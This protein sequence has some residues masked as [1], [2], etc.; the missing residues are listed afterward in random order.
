MSSTTINSK[1]QASALLH[2]GDVETASD[3]FGIPVGDWIDLST[4]ISPFAYPNTQISPAALTCM[5]Y[6]TKSFERASSK[7]YALANNAEVPALAACNGSQQVISMLPQ[8]LAQLPVLLPNIGYAEHTEAWRQA[9]AEINVYNALDA[10][11]AIDEIELQ[12]SN[13]NACHVVV[14]NPNNPSGITFSA[15][16]LLGWA[17]RLQGN[18]KLIIDEAFIDVAP[19]Q[20]VLNGYYHA[21]MVVL[22]SFGKF[23]GLPGLRLGFVFAT[24]D[25]GKRIKS[26][27]GLWDI[28]GPAQE[29]A[30]GAFDDVVWQRKTREA[31]HDAAAFNEALWQPLLQHIASQ[32]HPYAAQQCTLFSSYY[33]PLSLAQTWY[34]YFASHGVLL[35]LI[36]AH[37]SQAFIRVGLIDPKSAHQVAHINYVINQSIQASVFKKGENASDMQSERKYG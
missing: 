7:Y 28:N 16:R 25:I 33:L 17:R 9:G 37:D 15:E 31:L 20:S 8:V 22:R 13:N 21:N 3:V 4:G 35:R 10:Q 11:Q 24:D 19:E 5:P 27:I 12:L 14:I 30:V 32:G 23:F 34:A 2:G 36:K 1:L 26:N 18:A 6:Q 29:I